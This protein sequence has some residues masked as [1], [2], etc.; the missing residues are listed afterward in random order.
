VMIAF[1][2]VTTKLKPD[3]VIVVGDV[4]S[5]VACALAS[6]KL[7]IPVA[8][9][10]AGLRSFDR[11]MPEEINRVVTD[12]VSTY[13]FT[14]SRFA[15][16]NLSGEGINGDNVFFVGNVMI[17]SL[18]RFKQRACARNT[19]SKLKLGRRGYAVFTL[20]RPSNV[21]DPSRLQQILEALET[22]QRALP[23]VF[24]AHPRVLD[25]VLSGSI[26]KW[27]HR[28][29]HLSVI[30]P[31]G[32][33]DFLCLINNARLVLTDSGG[34][35][36]ETTVLGI[37]CL[38]LRENTERPETVAEGTN[39]LVGCDRER[40]VVEASK[41]MQGG[42]KKAATP[43]LWDGRSAERIVDTLAMIFGRCGRPTTVSRQTKEATARG[44][45]KL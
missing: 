14:T 11:T 6:A 31:L 37:P 17:D 20:H 23:V 34:L 24:P 13:L 4:N 45:L 5:T 18:L 10:E 15:N 26:S 30:T 1:E 44:E 16:D 3:L 21:D 25:R 29:G 7:N 28:M 9:I 19:L 38:T 12:H 22:I 2:K 41:A 40:I 32:Y 35:Q 36:E 27:L 33:L 42:I 8:H 39:V 43:E